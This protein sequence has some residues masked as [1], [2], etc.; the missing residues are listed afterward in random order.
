MSKNLYAY[1][2]AGAGI[3]GNVGK[4]FAEG[5]ILYGPAQR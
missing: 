4:K 5:I 2:G 1:L 3:G